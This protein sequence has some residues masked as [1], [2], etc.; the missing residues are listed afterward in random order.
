MDERLKRL[1][2]CLIEDV[3]QTGEPVGSQNLVE[4]HKLDVSPATVRN[5]FAELESNGF[6]FQ[7]HTSAGRIPTEK[8]Y[9]LYVDE[10]MDRKSL[11]K[12]ERLELERSVSGNA[13]EGGKS[14]KALS[15]SAAELS[16]NAVVLGLNEADTFYTGLTHLFAQPEFRDW[17]RMVSLGE[18][19][20]RLDEVLQAIRKQSFDAPV[21]LIG[22]QCPFGNA[23][24]SI[25]MTLSD[26]TL[27][28]LLGPMRMD[29]RQGFALL[30]AAKEII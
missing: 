26:G 21:A 19:L 10:L 18:A 24:G 5:W 17:N 11:N 23:C 1:L 27:I 15:K 3:I 12:K 22:R 2:R 14:A 4:T 16:S 9:R 25:L 29:Y 28:G 6:I 8:G 7:P 30:D 13:D 20:D